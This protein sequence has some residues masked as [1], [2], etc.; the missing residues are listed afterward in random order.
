VV[1]YTSENA[2]TLKGEIIIHNEAQMANST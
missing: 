2:K 1:N